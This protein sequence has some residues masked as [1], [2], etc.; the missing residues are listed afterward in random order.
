MEHGLRV[1]AHGAPE[2]RPVLGERHGGV[3]ALHAR[4]Q[5]QV[6][7]RLDNDAE[8]AVSADRA[9]EE[10]RALLAARFGEGAVVQHELQRPCRKHQRPQA[11]V[12][13][14]HV[15]AER[16]ADREVGVGLHDLDR[17]AVRVDEALDVA[18]PHSGLHPDRPRFGR[19]RDDPVHRAHVEVQ[20]ARAR[21]LAAHA[22]AATADRYRA[23]RTAH[24]LLD[25]LD[26]GRRDDR[27][28]AHRVE[29]RDVVDDMVVLGHQAASPDLTVR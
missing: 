13:A 23:G 17:E 18:P 28:H 9:E 26:R 15:D 16:T 3:R 20:A 1:V 12:A 27:H 22:E 2:V 5:R 7:L 25:F 14:V 19:E 4:V 8:R 21:G 6:E 10:I 11:H 29:L 24:G